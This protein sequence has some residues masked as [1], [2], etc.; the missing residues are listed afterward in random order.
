MSQ[1][2]LTNLLNSVEDNLV[3][4]CWVNDEDSRV[5]CPAK[6]ARED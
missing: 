4:I 6:I 2:P 3:Q 1:C 5:L